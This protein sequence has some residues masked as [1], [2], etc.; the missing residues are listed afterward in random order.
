MCFLSLSYN[1]GAQLL[2]NGY[3]VGRNVFPTVTSTMPGA[4]PQLPLCIG[5]C[6][7]VQ[8]TTTSTTTTSTTTTTTT[9][10]IPKSVTINVVMNNVITA[11]GSIGTLS[12]VGALGNISKYTCNYILC[13]YRSNSCIQHCVN[14]DNYSC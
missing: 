1:G 12:K 3:P 2:I 5:Q 7:N 6:Q 11:G 9:A 4:F 13:F 8:Q 10:A 14:G